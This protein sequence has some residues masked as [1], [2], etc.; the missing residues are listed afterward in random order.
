MTSTS[1]FGGFIFFRNSKNFAYF[2]MSYVQVDRRPNKTRRFEML[3]V[4]ETLQCI[5][6]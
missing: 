2:V 4:I 5:G 1:R 3:D 6:G